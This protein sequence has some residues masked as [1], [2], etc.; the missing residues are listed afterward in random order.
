MSTA[1][2]IT[3]RSVAGFAAN[4]ARVAAAGDPD[5]MLPTL[6]T[7]W[8]WT[9]DGDTTTFAEHLLR[10]DWAHLD[11]LTYTIT[12]SGPATAGVGVYADP[13]AGTANRGDARP[14]TTGTGWLYV[15][16]TFDEHVVVF[17]ATT[18]GMWAPHS[19]HRLHA[20][21]DG[22]YSRPLPPHGDAV[23]ADHVGHRWRPARVSVDGLATAWPADVCTGEHARGVVVVRID[24]DT[25]AQAIDDLHEFYRLRI[26]G[27][28]LPSH[29]LDGDLLVTTWFAGTPHAQADHTYADRD[30]RFI[31]GPHIWPWIVSYGDTALDEQQMRLRNGTGR[32]R[33]WVSAA[34]FFASNPELAG[35]T[36]PQVCAAVTALAGDRGV[37]VIEPDRGGDCVWLVAPSYALLITPADWDHIAHT[38]RLPR[39]LAGS[40]TADTPVPVLTVRQ[41]AAACA[42]PEPSTPA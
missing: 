20:D 35:Y 22:C 31:L 9:F 4:V 40:W 38:V 18:L 10:H 11:P 27:S 13:P 8:R 41:V 29:R 23:T 26:P 21:A 28:G 16:D 14:G 24:H 5:R 17:S 19:R 39:P 1:C 42:T 36:L 37:A 34:G 7:I 6:R 32:L 30:G 15:I 3:S 25:L 12:D 2:L 33:D